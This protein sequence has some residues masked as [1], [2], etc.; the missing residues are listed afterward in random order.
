MI[1]PI[2]GTAGIRLAA[3]RCLNVEPRCL[4]MVEGQL[5]VRIGSQ[6]IQPAPNQTYSCDV[7]LVGFPQARCMGT[8]GAPVSL[9][10]GYVVSSTTTWQTLQAAGVVPAGSA[11]ATSAS[12]ALQLR[13]LYSTGGFL[14][15]DL[16][17]DNA[18]LV[19]R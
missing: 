14:G 3:E 12:A 9:R 19:S 15:P 7:T 17:L 11:L 5:Q 1:R 2:G 10:A 6:S 8:A 16:D 4:G 13:C 18:S